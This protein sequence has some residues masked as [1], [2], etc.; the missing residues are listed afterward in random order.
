MWKLIAL[1][2]YLRK[3]QRNYESRVWRRGQLSI[4]QAG[5]GI[6]GYNAER[7]KKTKKFW[8]LCKLYFSC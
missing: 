3:I 1:S 4:I 5:G 8:H 7:K 6:R 2:K